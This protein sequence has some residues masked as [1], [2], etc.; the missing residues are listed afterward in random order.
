M[1]CS[2]FQQCS[3]SNNPVNMTGQL[4]QVPSSITVPKLVAQLF[5]NSIARCMGT[6]GAMLTDSA[7][8]MCV[9]G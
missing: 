6:S 4:D 5:M 1:W 8:D 3:A 9:L 2:H 7:L